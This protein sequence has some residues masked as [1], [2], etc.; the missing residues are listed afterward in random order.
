MLSVTIY[1]VNLYIHTYMYREN[2]HYLKE[3]NE[4]IFKKSSDSII[5]PLYLC[6]KIPT[7]V[8]RGQ[9]ITQ[10]HFWWNTVIF[11]DQENCKILISLSFNLFKI[12][13]A[14]NKNN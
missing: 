13:D 6:L 5:S 14:L 3:V 9:S 2:T 11:L 4:G 12:C 1:I 10:S 7:P 8:M